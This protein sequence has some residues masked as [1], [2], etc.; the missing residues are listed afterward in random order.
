LFENRYEEDHDFVFFQAEEV[1]AEC[2]F[3]DDSGGEEFVKG[4]EQLLEGELLV[5]FQLIM[6][7]DQLSFGVF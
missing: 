1:L 3:L 5:V 6:G 7:N 4:M 2:V